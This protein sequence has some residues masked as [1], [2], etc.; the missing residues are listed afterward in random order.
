MHGAFFLAIHAIP[1]ELTE[2]YWFGARTSPRQR[3]KTCAMY[4][5]FQRFKRSTKVSPWTLQS[6]ASSFSAAI[7]TS[8]FLAYFSWSPFRLAEAEAEAEAEATT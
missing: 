7:A 3:H 6:F 8:G 1:H 4:N 2:Q 5:T